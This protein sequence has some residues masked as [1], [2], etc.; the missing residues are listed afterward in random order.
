MRAGRAWTF[1]IF[2][3]ETALRLKGEWIAC[4]TGVAI[5]EL[6]SIL[7]AIVSFLIGIRI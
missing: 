3:A 4:A 5:V 2:M 7:A 6:S 1:H